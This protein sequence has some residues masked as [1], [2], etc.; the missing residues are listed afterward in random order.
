MSTY[1]PLTKWPPN[2]RVI[3]ICYFFS[4]EYVLSS[5]TIPKLF[6]QAS[7]LRFLFRISIFLFVKG[8]I[9]APINHMKSANVPKA[10]SFMKATGIILARKDRQR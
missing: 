5:T 9:A 6:I 2:F 8:G 10:E 1:L 7:S 3:L 4:A